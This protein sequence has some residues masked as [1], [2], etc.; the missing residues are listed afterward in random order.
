MYKTK[1]I[2]WRLEKPEHPIREILRAYHEWTLIGQTKYGY[3]KKRI[4][5]EK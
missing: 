2:E 5:N 3:P 1:P 4:K